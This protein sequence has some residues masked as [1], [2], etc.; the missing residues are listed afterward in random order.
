M[1]SAGRAGRFVATLFGRASV[2]DQVSAEL[3]FHVDMLARELEATGMSADAAA[4]E[5]RRRFGD[6]ERVRSTC[7][8][9]AHLRDR[10][11][12]R[13]LYVDE[14]RQDLRYAVRHLASAP[15]FT[16]AAALTLA[17]GIGATAAVF[18][19]VDSVVLRPFAWAHADRVVAPVEWW[20]NL[21]GSV[22]AA[23][24]IDWRDQ[25]KGFTAMAA[26]RYS[27][28]NL[29]D[30]PTPERVESGRVTSNF[31]AVFGVPPLLG[32]TFRP[33]EDEPGHEQVAILSEGLW[34]RLFGADPTILNKTTRMNGLPVTVIG[35]MPRSFDLSSGEELWMPLALTPA[36]QLQRDDHYLT[37]IGLLSPTTPLAQARAEMDEIG[38]R[39]A[40][41]YPQE[42]GDRSARV[43]T[44]SDVI[45]GNERPR[46]LAVL[47]AVSFVLL[48]ACGNVANLLL[49]RGAA[50]AKEIA[51]RGAL[52]A[53]RG[54][55]VRQLLTESLVLATF[56][57]VLG[58]GLAWLGI[59]IFVASAP[60][61]VFPRLE[62]T[63]IDG[64]VLAFAVAITV[65]SAVLFGLAPALR[66]ARLEMQGTL[67]AGGRG[68]GGV[69]DR[70]RAGL[71]MAEIALAL[72][73]LHGAG[74]LVRSAI[75][76]DRTPLGFDPAGVLT[77][78]LALPV[79]TYGDPARA[80]MAFDQIVTALRS[81]PGV[82]AAAVVSQAPMGAGRSSNGLI[83]EG[84]ALDPRSAIDAWMRLASP[85]YL[86]VMQIPVVSGRAFTDR[87]VAGAPRVMLVS[88][89]LAARAWPGQDPIGKRV[90]CCEG[91]L[92]DPRWKTVVGV[93]GDVRSAG[94]AN[95]L[96]PEFYLPIAQAPAAA[97]D[98]VQR[99]MTLAARTESDASGPVTA[100][101]R[102][103]VR[104]VDPTLPIYDVATMRQALRAST[105][106][107]RFDTL[108][109]TV[110]AL[111]GLV[112]AG[113]G[114]ASVVA[115]LVTART[116]EIGVRLALGATAG[117]IVALFARQ[118]A[119]PIL[120]GVVLGSAGAAAASRI[121]RG[122]L[123]GVSTLDPVSA[124]IVT[125]VLVG[126]AVVATLIPARRVAQI[127]P[128]RVLE[129]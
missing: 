24:Y 121:L 50:R 35:V 98:W 6:L 76:L 75:Q 33:D 60:V 43:L 66:A 7:R 94:P 56:A 89:T 10:T 54:R 124:G 13:T 97:W 57:A 3:E 34:R 86:S 109:L 83:P 18:G 5:A 23:N 38:R 27:P 17:L 118:S 52:G 119:R 26:E 53:R 110:L 84:R 104:S 19:A 91:S 87:D 1:P 127:D 29:S 36:Q 39:L 49:A 14:L 40:Q 48:I 100:S 67:R 105:A 22:S 2:D 126:V 103:A 101:V 114:I 81:E 85:D 96:Y 30:G 116:H 44:L 125:I 68:M 129:G 108:L 77:A 8:D 4:A 107:H 112:L 20:N 61:G 92:Q 99:T 41:R 65:A 59:K 28:V 120:A 62:D 9:A 70:L 37:V 69:R 79:S 58:L 12:H 88:R 122:S 55:I 21:A 80:E 95:D 115:F 31:F 102:H 72:V 15:A 113:A 16:A 111:I 90:A 11:L 123:Y 78:R 45:I 64:R 32:R 51:I 25:A 71:V 106:E 42:D 74:L 117:E 46:L 82:T 73:L 128:V 63:H 47:G 93:V